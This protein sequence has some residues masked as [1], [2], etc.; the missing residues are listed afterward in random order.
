MT[1][2]PVPR[3]CSPGLW[4]KA[5]AVAILLASRCLAN[6]PP[7]QPPADLSEASLET[8]MNMEVSSPGRKD[9]KLS[10][11]AGAIY[12]VTQE[13]IRRS[14]VTSIP[15]VLRM[16]PGLQV[17]QIDASQWAVTC[18][19]FNGRFADKMLV[20]IDGRT[21]YNNLFGGVY[22]EQND[23]PLEDIERIEV[24]RGPGA[25]MWGANAV[26]GV[27][28]IITRPAQETQGFLVTSGGGNA[29]R[30]FGS[31]R[32]G[33]ELGDNASYRLYTRYFDRGPFETVNSQEAHD[34]WDSAQGGGRMDWKISERDSL[35]VE[36]EVYRDRGQETIYPDYPENTLSAPL[37]D[38]LDTSGGYALA[39][40]KRQI[41]DRSGMAL[42]FSFSEENR[43]EGFGVADTRILDLDF[44]QHFTASSRHDLMWGLEFTAYG[45]HFES[46][47]ISVEPSTFV[48]FLPASVI[49]PFASGFLQDEIALL[50]ERLTLTLGTKLERDVYMGL[51]A[52]PSARLLWAPTSRQS[53]W[54]AVSRAVR[55]PARGERDLLL[56]FEAAPGVLGTLSGP[57]FQPQTALAYEAGY[58]N[59]PARWVTLDLAAFFCNYRDLRSMEIGAP[60]LVQ[61]PAPY[62]LLPLTF[63]NNAAGHTYGIE[64]A[65]DWSLTRRW[66]VTGNY[67]WF[68]YVL[69]RA[70]L[71]PESL[72][73]DVEGSSPAHQV[74]FRS[75]WDVA[76]KLTFDTNVYFVS[77]LPAIGVPAYVRTDARLGWHVTRA[78]EL[79]LGGQNLLDG[80]HLEFISNDYVLSS[81]PGRTAYLKVTWA[82]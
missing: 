62:I 69:D 17:A 7:A 50:P 71:G 81:E 46:R 20:M 65:T 27:I 16:V 24:I 52:Q 19:G 36:G 59:Q 47:R 28:N 35:S 82:F 3:L 42:Q 77:A 61:A 38:S 70:D 79:S 74:Q 43:G 80:R 75:Q 9:Q 68:R 53:L 66:R 39:R 72:P 8:L 60:S 26:N 48:Q 67:S 44:Q 41:S 58:R 2:L 49:Q 14:G 54:A 23:V 25:T 57:N 1:A 34:G 63:G 55:P 78:A 22:W 21:I 40:W 31:V 5:I 10:Q 33:G 37:A 45:D 30:G 51:G 76:R 11:T 32:Y 18:R 6:D 13:D 12:V 56:E 64:L 4:A 73:Y 15:D 29:D